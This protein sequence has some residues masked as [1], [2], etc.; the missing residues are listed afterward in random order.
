MLEKRTWFTD[1]T[2]ILTT[3]GW[4][5]IDKMSKIED[6]IVYKDGKFKG[7]QIKEYNK[8]NYTGEI[9]YCKKGD[10]FFTAKEI[11]FPNDCI[12]RVGDCLKIPEVTKMKYEGI[13]F[14]ILTPSNTLITRTYT[15]NFHHNNDYL[16]TLCLVK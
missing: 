7:E 5:F 3:T 6:V 9:D 14:N 2:E 11:Y 4:V 13:L 12:F 1:N 15:H 16:L 10:I 8:F